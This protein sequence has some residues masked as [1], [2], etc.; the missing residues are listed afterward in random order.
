MEQALLIVWRESAEA[1]LV[2]G[3]L[4]A[5]LS[6]QPQRHRHLRLL[7]AGVAGARRWPACWRP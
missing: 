5:W 6:R 7:W 3:L 1:L 2:I 4:Y